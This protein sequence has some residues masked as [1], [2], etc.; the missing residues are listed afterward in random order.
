MA[1]SLV[2]RGQQQ[3]PFGDDNKK[4]NDKRQRCV[5]KKKAPAHAIAEQAA[6]F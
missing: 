2:E 3:I 6:N 5:P 4:G 1:R